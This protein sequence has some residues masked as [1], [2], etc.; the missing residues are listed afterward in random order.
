MSDDEIER[1]LDAVERELGVEWRDA[2]RWIVAQNP[3]GELADRI[4]TSSAPAAI[5]LGIEDAAARV[6]SRVVAG[7][8]RGA[9]AAA[10]WLD[11]QIGD[12]LISY[13]A[14]NARAAAW[15]RR[16]ALELRGGITSEAREVVRV[17]LLHGVARG[18]NPV[19]IAR[20]L[21]DTIGLT[22][23]QAGHVLTYRRALEE[24]D[25]AAALARDLRDRRYD[26]ALRRAAAAGEALSS[27][28]IDEMVARY[29][30]RYVAFRARTIARTE[31]LAAVHQGADEGLQ[32]A[33]DAGGV[34]AARLVH[35]WLATPGARTRDT[36]A[37]MSGQER[38]HGEPFASPSG[39]L[40]R[41]PGDP[42]API[43]ERANCRCKRTTR[44]RLA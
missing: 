39:A 2:A 18:E 42:L 15:V 41:F 37:E 3:P 19:S 44:L 25:A 14:G 22:P 1:V 30:E 4:A 40:L 7:Y 10:A 43:E 38:G 36:H 9:E 12:R 33:V 17:V 28:K 31:A 21:H 35:T 8:G 6:A 13:D 5:L 26:R 11:A 20:D 32:Q 24:G 27:S 23:T 34:D 29:H 16:T